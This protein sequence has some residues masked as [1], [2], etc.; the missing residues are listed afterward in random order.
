[1]EKS[2]SHI[3]AIAMLMFAACDENSTDN[4]ET[5]SDL[6]GDTYTNDD[7]DTTE[8]TD[9]DP[10]TE[11]DTDYP[12]PDLV[13]TY[14]G[15]APDEETRLKIFDRLW[16]K[17]AVDYPC[18]SIL[19]I[20]WDAI[21]DEYRPQV[22]EATSYGRFVQLL[23][24]MIHVLHDHHAKFKSMRISDTPP[25]DRPPRFVLDDRTGYLG[26]CVT[27]LD[28]GSLMVYRADKDNPAGLTP[29][30]IVIG[31]DGKPWS[32]LL[33]LIDTWNLPTAGAPGSAPTA[34]EHIRLGSVLNNAHLF[35][36][37]DVEKY[38]SQ[39][40][41]SIPTEPL[42]DFASPIMCTDQL[43][44]DGIEF[45]NTEWK[46]IPAPWEIS[47]YSYAEWITWGIIPGTNI[48]FIYPYFWF[49]EPVDIFS[50]AIKQL[51][52]TDGLI[53]DQRFNMGGWTNRTFTVMVHN[54]GGIKYLFGEDVPR[55]FHYVGRDP[56]KRDDYFALDWDSP[57]FPTAINANENT[58]Y[59]RPIAVLT[60]IKAASGG[61]FFPYMMSHHPRVRR[62]GRL[63]DGSFA[64]TFPQWYPTD[65][66]IQDLQL[67]VTTTVAVNADDNLMQ[68]MEEYPEEE[69]WLTQ[70]DAAKG[71]D[72]VIKAALEWIDQENESN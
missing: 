3:Y 4:A 20:D 24:A 51:K 52:D 12:W 66:F 19:D 37:L 43:P 29:G 49:G 8:D 5:D 44:V 34:Q 28:D 55:I 60:G 39:T 47:L 14:W 16:K 7:T 11:I 53:I 61:D 70:E 64:G 18:F 65:P 1:M 22:E 62:F 25:E 9:T 58:F 68:A 15:E 17:F 45:P 32:E 13:D 38:G 31:Y 46:E 36:R 40:S 41:E 26:A 50:R 59:D 48:G 33:D 42:L 67:N 23:T 63:T 2:R 6:D 72:T 71:V 27:M 57:T 35:Y 54:M 56:A 21:R 10:D 30:D 69:I